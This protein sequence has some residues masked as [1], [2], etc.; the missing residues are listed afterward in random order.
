M[1]AAAD[2]DDEFVL[3]GVDQRELDVCRAGAARDQR[4][5]LVED[6]VEPPACRVVVRML[7]PDQLPANLESKLA[8]ATT[9]IG[10]PPRGDAGASSL[11][12]SQTGPLPLGST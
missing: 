4:R 5:P 12:D 1:A 8:C 7:G 3:A 6:A 11:T 9:V 10:V 2:G